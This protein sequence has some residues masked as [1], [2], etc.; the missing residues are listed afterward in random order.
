MLLN[1]ISLFIYHI[2]LNKYLNI[3]SFE[4]VHILNI[5]LEHL[6]G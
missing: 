6:V 2:I 5:F 3:L 1:Y 4:H